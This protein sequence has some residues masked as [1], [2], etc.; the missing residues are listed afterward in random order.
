MSDDRDGALTGRCTCGALRYRMT[1]KPLFFTASKQ[2]WV[3]IP[4]GAAAVQ[5][6][7]KA[8]K[9]WPADSLARWK[10]LRG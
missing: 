2:P 6:Y 8:G 10:A 4:S 9:H 3:V 7:Y 1:S 5:A